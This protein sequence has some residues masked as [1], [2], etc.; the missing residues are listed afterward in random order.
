M[1]REI[2]GRD[3]EGARGKCLV[4]RYIDAADPGPIH[5]DMGNKVAAFI[6][7]RDVHGLV[8][9]NRFVFRGAD[10]LACFLQRNHRNPRHY[11][12]CK[13]RSKQMQ[14]LALRLT[15]ARRMRRST[16][17]NGG[18]RCSA[19]HLCSCWSKRLACESVIVS[20]VRHAVRVTSDSYAENTQSNAVL[21]FSH[22]T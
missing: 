12:H 18:E 14:C 17:L 11:K 9:F 8:D 5:A 22:L 15:L 4:D 1:L 2:P 7:N 10:N 6:D 13:C 3:I 21:S 20:A 16:V 19:S